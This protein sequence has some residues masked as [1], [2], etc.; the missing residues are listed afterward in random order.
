MRRALSIIFFILGGWVLASEILTAFMDVQ[1]GLRDSVI[2][3]GLFGALA[4]VPLLLGAWATPGRRWNELG[5][6]ILLGAGFGLIAV[7][8]IGAMMVDPGAKPYL[9]S[10]RGLSFAP[11]VGIANLLFVCALGIM[12]YR[13]G[14][15]KTAQEPAQAVSPS[16]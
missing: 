1:P 13:T 11:V 5:L 2:F 4:A 12:L 6:T 10:M 16:A 8:T 14:R 9:P 15:P 3:I 7:V